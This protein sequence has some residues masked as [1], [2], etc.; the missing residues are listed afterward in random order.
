MNGPNLDQEGLERYSRQII[1]EEIGPAGQEA[2]LKSKI[3]V[4][5]AGGLGAPVIQYLAAA[6]VGTIGIIDS[7]SVEISN[8]HRQII[9]SVKDIGKPKVECALNFVKGINPN[10]NVETYHM[11]V[12]SNNILDLISGYDFVVDGTDNFES[13]F[14]INDACTLGKKP[15]SYGAVLRFSGRVMTFPATENSPC[16]RCIFKIAPPPGTT[17]DCATAGVMGSVAGV[18]G[19]MQATE[20][21][22]NIV[23][24]GKSE[25][26]K[27]IEYNALNMTFEEAKIKKN[28]N[29]P[30]CGNNPVIKN[31]KEVEYS[32]VCSVK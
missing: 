9:Y 4:I 10:V 25:G 7:D 6:G 3:L 16:Y 31:I 13:C 28:P 20:A 30:I 22:K 14:L 18:I 11:K 29:C 1:M 19:S 2:I 27:I 21:I 12:D 15:Y 24:M 23:K 8:L 5:G 32:G 17:L 26:G